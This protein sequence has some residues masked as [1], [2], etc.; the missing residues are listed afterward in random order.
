MEAMT[1]VRPDVTDDYAEAIAAGLPEGDDDISRELRVDYL[2][3]RIGQEMGEIA[4]V[5]EFTQRR[6]QMVRDHGDEQA[7]LIQRRIAHLEAMVRAHLPLTGDE[8]ASQYRKR[9]I[10]LPHGK[11]GYRATPASVVI[12][13]QTAAIEWARANGVPVTVKESVGKTGVLA[14]IKTTG[15]LPETDAIEYVDARE[16]FYVEPAEPVQ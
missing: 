8:F 12:H 6:V 4:K 9:S 1:A 10:S 5:E 7:A 14:H 3:E 13:D 15:A 16:R 2:L 11:V